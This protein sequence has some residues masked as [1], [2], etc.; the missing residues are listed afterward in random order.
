MA[1]QD[2]TFW[3][4]I[5]ENQ[6][7]I[8]V[9]Q[10]DY[11]HGRTNE[12][13]SSIREGFLNSIEETLSCDSFS[14]L[15]LDF[16]YGRILGKEKLKVQLRNKQAIEK[17]LEAV[18]GYASSL[19]MDLTFGLLQTSKAVFVNETKFEPLDGQQ[20]LT[21]LFL[22]HW[23][24]IHRTKSHLEEYFNLLNGFQ[25][26]TR[27]TSNEFCSFLTSSPDI[28]ALEFSKIQNLQNSIANCSSFYKRWMND[29]TVKGMLNMLEAIHLRFF[30]VEDDIL[31]KYLSRL[32]E[33]RRITFDFLDLDQLEQTDELY[34]KMN[35]RGKQLSD[36][37][38]FK[39]WL[40]DRFE[41]EKEIWDKLDT[42][43]INLFWHKK[44]PNTFAVDDT[45]YEFIK[46]INAFEYI[47]QTP[48]S[49]I[50]SSIIDRI[51]KSQ[52]IPLRQFEIEI[53]KK[54]FNFFTKESLRFVFDS[55]DRLKDDSVDFLNKE[56]GNVYTNAF[57]K[58]NPEL[59]DFFLRSGVR[60]NYW[61]RVYYYSFI[62]FLKYGKGVLDESFDSW[63]R[64]SR[65]LIYNTY[66]QNPTDFKKA[67]KAL[68]SFSKE[69]FVN[70]SLNMEDGIAC[71]QYSISFFDAQYK[72][73]VKK[74]HYIKKSE[75]WRK[76]IEDCENHEYF[77]GQIG[78]LFELSNNT[79]DINEFRHLAKQCSIFF[80]GIGKNDFIFQ[81]SLLSQGDY[82]ISPGNSS[83]FSFCQNDFGSL[84]VR[85]DNWRKV[86]N[87]K[88]GREVLKELI[89]Q[90]NSGK[91]L[92]ELVQVT[93]NM[94]PWR[95][96]IIQYP[97][98]ISYTKDKLVDFKSSLDVRLLKGTTYKGK[99]FDLFLFVLLLKLKKEEI[100]NLEFRRSDINNYR[101]ENSFPEINVYNQASKSFLFSINYQIYPEAKYGFEIRF[102]SEL[103][104]YQ[105]ELIHDFYELNTRTY[106]YSF[107]TEKGLE[108]ALIKI[109]E[110]VTKFNLII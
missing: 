4:I 61:D 39:A 48:E 57:Q 103:N 11:A 63:M 13:V 70:N 88:K 55:I 22:L 46:N 93:E 98:I 72:E 23:Y 45:I 37:E 58:S 53:E 2:L 35:A 52:Y 34:V 31:N 21:T 68:H 12:R 15:H 84:R 100:V 67:V 18:Q 24:L 73:E 54:H 60:F 106:S 107:N 50:E 62:L 80:K 104:V 28:Q 1:E 56:L 74:I 69:V 76:V 78:F 17:V 10:R 83:K 26:K 89:T 14:K 77:F 64:V 110:C 3:E 7:E 38:H 75:D 95:K 40:Q 43:W 19:D 94:E 59:K 108:E 41:F 6:I 36:Y 44:A 42:D 90:M 32:I 82:L 97:E 81:R 86:Y 16:I 79:D 30:K 47:V 29:P 101:N 105:K 25:Y 92:E 85:N 65:N 27:N 102:E 109:V 8:P 20:R 87:K 49:K 5:S 71:E 99:H 9:I 91:S 96:Y 51:S 66:I 33:E